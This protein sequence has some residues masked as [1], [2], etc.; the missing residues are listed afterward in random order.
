MPTAAEAD[1]LAVLWRLGPATVREVHEALEKDCD[2]NTTLTQ[3]RLMT[4]KG[5]LIRSERFRSHVY[6]PAAPKNEMQQQIA[7]D[8]VKRVFGGSAKGLI[9][10]ALGAKQT[11]SEERAEI[12]RMLDEL[13]KKKRRL[14]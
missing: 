9:M 10:S 13:D 11:T 5:L 4:D 14:K 1:I 6:E 7:R 12:R 2:Y 3:M 8:L